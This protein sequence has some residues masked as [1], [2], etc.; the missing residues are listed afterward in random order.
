MVPSDQ[1]VNPKGD[2]TVPR[3]I[4]LVMKMSGTSSALTVGEWNGRGVEQ[5][6]QGEPC[7]DVDTGCLDI[8]PFHC[9][10]GRLVL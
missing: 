7:C 9:D 10:H 3:A 5:E 4:Q 8:I 6:V 2:R 1:I